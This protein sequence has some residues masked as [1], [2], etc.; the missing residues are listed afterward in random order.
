MM[1]EDSV[2]GKK[3]LAL[4]KE[5][6]ETYLSFEK[7]CVFQELLTYLKNDKKMN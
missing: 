3:D 2:T 7:Y 4:N 6:E 1:P 5:R